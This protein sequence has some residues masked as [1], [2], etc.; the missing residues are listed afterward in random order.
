MCMSVFRR[1]GGTHVHKIYL[2]F[3]AG[4]WLIAH[5]IN[6]I[7]TLGSAWHYWGIGIL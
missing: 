5:V 7:G 6:C 4:L 3:D 2:Y 1:S